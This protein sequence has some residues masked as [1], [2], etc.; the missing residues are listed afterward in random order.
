MFVF[1]LKFYESL[2]LKV[3]IKSALTGSGL[4]LNWQQAIFW[5]NDDLVW[6]QVSPG[7]HP[8]DDISI[9][10]EIRPKFGVL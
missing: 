6:W 9:E 10:L 7:A 5:S 3:E 2:F 4:A 1:W 8:T